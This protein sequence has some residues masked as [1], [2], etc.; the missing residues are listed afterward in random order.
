MAQAQAQTK[1]EAPSHA[2]GFS[3]TME[4]QEGYEFRVKFRDK[5]FL[6]FRA[7]QSERLGPDPGGQAALGCHNRSCPPRRDD[8]AG[9]YGK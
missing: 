6:P 8:C 2:H 7:A 4:Q 9:R 3:F 5:N 1:S